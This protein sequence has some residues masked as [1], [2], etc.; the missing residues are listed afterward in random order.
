ME[1]EWDSIDVSYPQYILSVSGWMEMV[2]VSSW[3]PKVLKV[4][5]VPHSHQDP[6][7]LFTYDDYYRMSARKVLS[8]MTK[9]LTNNPNWTFIWS[10]VTYLAKWWAMVDKTEQAQFNRLVHS[11]RVEIVTGGWVMPDEAVTLYTSLLDQLI[12]GNTWLKKHLG[13]TPNVSWSIDPFGHSPT[14]AYLMRRNKMDAMVTQRIHYG[15]KKYLQKIKGFEFLWRQTWAQGDDT[16]ILC[17]VMPFL[18]YDVTHSCGPDPHVCCQFDFSR[19]KCYHGTSRIAAVD[20]NDQNIEKLSWLLWEQLQ[21]KAELFPSGVLLVPYG[22]DFRYETER[23]WADLLGNMEKIV[24]YINKEERMNMEVKFGT[25]SDYFRELKESVPPVKSAPQT[26]SGDFFPYTDRDDQYWT[27]FYTS[28]PYL[29][30]MS[31]SLQSLLRS[32]EILLSMMLVRK[33]KRAWLIGTPQGQRNTTGV[34]TE[35]RRELGVFQHHD[36]VTGTSKAKVM[37]DYGKRLQRSYTSLQNLYS[38][39]VHSAMV[40]ENVSHH[41]QNN[42]QS[43]AD[44][45]ITRADGDSLK[46]EVKV[47]TYG[48]GSWSE[49]Y[50]DKSGAYTFMP[51]GNA[52]VLQEEIQGIYLISGPVYSQVITIQPAIIQKVTLYNTTGLLGKGLVIENIAAIRRHNNTELILRLETDVIDWNHGICTDLNG[53]QMH[54]RK[55]QGKLKIQGNLLPMTTMALLESKTYRLSVLTTSSRGVASQSPGCIEMAL[56]RRLMQHDWRGLNEGITDNVQA[57]SKF[58]VLLEKRS[59][60]STSQRDLSFRDILQGA[61][62]ES[63]FKTSVSGNQVDERIDPRDKIHL[64]PMEIQTY[65]VTVV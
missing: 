16:D 61:E 44:V 18:S 42:T 29:K 8:L 52:Q 41:Q 27:G 34:L 40:T 39:L 33:E 9:Q 26:L 35:A 13:V 43:N 28:R 57:Y 17:H 1:L 4:I 38:R 15:V 53:F 48:T 55:K 59:Q 14:M 23:E 56:D 54:R 22:D 20:V 19:K 25:L 64:P 30:A 60:T 58:V 49:F 37:A 24:K 62:I 11:G 10:E 47:M 65:L 32:T 2:T 51:N 3:Q 63:V 12:E 50:K 21:K 31:R 6:G 36:A 45:Y 7:W 46:T 5:I